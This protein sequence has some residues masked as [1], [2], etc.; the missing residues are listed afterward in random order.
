MARGFHPAITELAR[1][2]RLGTPEQ[3]YTRSDS[4]LFL[5]G[6]VVI[7]ALLDLSGGLAFLAALFTN[8]RQI[9]P[10]TVVVLELIGLGLLVL[11]I[12]GIRHA[13]TLPYYCRCT[14]GFL[15]LTR[16]NPPKVIQA[17]RWDDVTSTRKVSGSRTPTQYYIRT[18]HGK[19][20]QIRDGGIW[21]YCNQQVYLRTGNFS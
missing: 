12:Y 6:L 9:N 16:S 1:K 21:D 2:R 14:E 8:Q 7:L 18:R 10:G 5:W 13:R 17:L 19:E 20:I 15:E 11:C 4:V 3:L